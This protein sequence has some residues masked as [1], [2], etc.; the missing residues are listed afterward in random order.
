[1]KS[2]ILFLFLTSIFFPAFGQRLNKEQQYADFDTLCKKLEHVHPDLFLYQTIDEYNAKKSQIRASFTDS[3]KIADFYLKV[4]P[5]IASIKDGHSMI[6]PPMTEELISYV[7]NDG[8]TMPLRIKVTGDVFTVDYPMANTQIATGD[9]ILSINGISSKDILNRMYSLFASEKGNAIK[10]NTVQS[11]LSPLFWYLYQWGESYTF[12]A[13]RGN[14]IWEEKLNGISQSKALSIIKT[15][16]TNSKLANFTYELSSDCT[17][18][19]LIILNFYQES[20][21]EQFCDSVFKD[22]NDKQISELTIDVR[23]NSGGSSQC[24]EKFISYFPHPDYTLYSKS[25]IKISPDSKEYNRKRHK[26]LY[27]Q[28]CNHPN[29]DLFTINEIPIKENKTKANLYR[30]NITILVNGKTY[31]GASTFAHKMQ[32]FGLAQIK[33]ETGCPNIY[34]GN[35]LSFILPNSK[36]EYFI[37]STKFYE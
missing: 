17:K 13:K 35:F 26:E 27:L 15:K 6:L 22:I 28:L 34:F 30:G 37:T 33:G 21:L 24:V 5:F 16:Q 12:K 4:A 3:A 1:M 18:A 8:N 31:S 14:K 29:G 7:K 23:N 19:T 25:Q 9:T 2:L 10:E 36:L 32:A 20:A 11:Y